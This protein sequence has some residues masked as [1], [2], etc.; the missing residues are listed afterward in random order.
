LTTETQQI[1]AANNKRR[2][3]RQEGKRKKI[4]HYPLDKRELIT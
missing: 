1:G 3:N 4:F 2:A